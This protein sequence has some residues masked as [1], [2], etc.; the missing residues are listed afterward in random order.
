MSN[1]A[2]LDAILNVL[3]AEPINAKA[4]EEVDV[5]AFVDCLKE[6]EPQDA[7]G[8]V[9]RLLNAVF[10]AR[11]ALATQTVDL[12]DTADADDVPVDPRNAE[13]E[14]EEMREHMRR[15]QK[16]QREIVKESL[17]WTPKRTIIRGLTIR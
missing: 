7:M 10:A 15:I 3:L 1:K 5:A 2:T 12:S 9:W 16:Q 4:V 14:L 11:L 6:A 8:A 13:R 17:K